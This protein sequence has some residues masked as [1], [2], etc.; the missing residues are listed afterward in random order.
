MITKVS[1]TTL[2]AM[3]EAVSRRF[4][5]R[6]QSNLGGT[7]GRYSKHLVYNPLTLDPFTHSLALSLSPRKGLKDLVGLR[8]ATDT[9][10]NPNAP[11]LFLRWMERQEWRS[12][13]PQIWSRFGLQ[14]FSEN[15]T[16]YCTWQTHAN[17]LVISRDEPNQDQKKTNANSLP[18]IDV[19]KVDHRLDPKYVLSTMPMFLP[20]E[21]LLGY[22]QTTHL[23]T[24]PHCPKVCITICI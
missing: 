2:V 10:K 9:V 3:L 6:L 15:E 16:A 22:G 12:M 1:L 11:R 8:K 13:L 18:R 24:P 21:M 5:Q 17:T 23:G 4:P 14:T 20:S 19:V 7:W